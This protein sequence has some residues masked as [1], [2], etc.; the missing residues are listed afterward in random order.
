MERERYIAKMTKG[1]DGRMI[2]G[3]GRTSDDYEVNPGRAPPTPIVRT[4]TLETM[5][6]QWNRAPV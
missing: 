5:S 4:I 1:H 3:G 6:A 2:V